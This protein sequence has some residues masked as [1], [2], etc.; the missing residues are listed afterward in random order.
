L[1]PPFFALAQKH[2]QGDG[3]QNNQNKQDAFLANLFAILFLTCYFVDYPEHV[4][5]WLVDHGEQPIDFGGSISQ[6]SGMAQQM[7]DL[8]AENAGSF[9]KQISFEKLSKFALDSTQKMSYTK[10]S[11][12][13][14][15]SSSSTSSSVDI[16]EL[17]PIRYRGYYWDAETE[18]YFLQTRYYN[19]E[20]RRFINADCL[21]IAGNVLTASN[22]YAYCNNNPVMR[23]DPSGM[24]S[25]KLN[26]VK[27][28][29]EDMWLF[30]RG[31]TSQVADYGFRGSFLDYI[32]VLGVAHMVNGI[33][34]SSASV[35]T[36][37]RN[38][39]ASYVVYQ[40]TVRIKHGGN[41]WDVDVIVGRNRN[42][43]AYA[44]Y[45]EQQASDL[46]NSSLDIIL[47]RIADIV[48]DEDVDIGLWGLIFSIPYF[49][50][51]GMSLYNMYNDLA[52]I[53]NIAI[54][55]PLLHHPDSMFIIP[56]TRT[57]TV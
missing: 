25:H 39:N 34:L 6:A 46:P 3:N 54:G 22:M 53:I 18:Y 56:I 30:E 23:V 1:N 38:Y 40:C 52:T 28:P 27:I 20:W 9:Q 2:P 48:E 8:L 44:A 7:N 36:I 13:S 24:A 32:A 29:P 47:E 43:R 10:N 17:N 31:Y 21:F 37:N 26:R 45:L 12:N 15:Q 16:G 5:I 4:N 11:N 50:K 51:A 14:Q 35:T 41:T 57:I 19:P 42:L 55:G 33:I 49:A